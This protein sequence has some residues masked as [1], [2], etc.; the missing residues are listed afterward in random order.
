M[1]F[2]EVALPRAVGEVRLT[3]RL[4]ERVRLLALDQCLTCDY[5]GKVYEVHL[6]G[7]CGLG[8]RCMAREQYLELS[9]IACSICTML[10]GM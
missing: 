5:G 3:K 6:E 10:F 2:I 8:R 1:P 4:R 7:I 9:H